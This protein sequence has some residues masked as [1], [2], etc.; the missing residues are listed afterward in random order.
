VTRVHKLI[1]KPICEA[2]CDLIRSFELGLKESGTTILKFFLHISK[3]VQLARFCKRLDDPLRNWK[4]SESDYS[5][6]PLWDAYMEAIEAAL[7]ATST[8]EAPWYVIP[9]NHKWFRNLA[10]SRIVAD[11][12]E[13][14]GMSFPEPAV[15]LG[16]IRL[17]Y[18]AAASEERNNK[19]EKAGGGK[20]RHNP[21]LAPVPTCPGPSWAR[22]V[23][24]AWMP[25]FFSKKSAIFRDL[26]LS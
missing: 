25:A 26:A 17:K 21:W 5:E 14:L 12:M 4:I 13:A 18:H 24:R 19:K 22:L 2:R 16:E 8:P 23:V 9:A 7:S 1:D 10:V 11:T 20:V 3:E 6:R 15:D